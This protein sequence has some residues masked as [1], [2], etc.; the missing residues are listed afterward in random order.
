MKKYWFRGNLLVL[1]VLAVACGGQTGSKYP[2]PVSATVNGVTS[3]DATK[4][5]AQLSVSA[6][7]AEG[8]LLEGG[9]ISNVQVTTVNSS[10][11]AGT[12][13]GDVCGNIEYSG[14]SINAILMLDGSGSMSLTDPNELR[15]DAAKQFVDRMSATDKAAIGSFSDGV[16]IPK[17]EDLTS[18]KIAL[19]Q[20]IDLNTYVSGGTNLWG[21]TYQSTD[22]ISTSTESN[23]IAVV[24]TDGEDNY[25]TYSIQ[26]I[27]DNATSKSVK[28]FMV[29]LG[30]GI[31][32]AQMTQVAQG[33][34]G[35]YSA[36]DN[37]T[38]LNNLFNGAFNAATSAGCIELTFN[39]VPPTGTKLEG[40]INFEVEDT[41]LQAPFTISF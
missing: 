11:W 41:P 26:Q 2:K 30:S 12:G 40:E 34:T 33:T 21:A 8:K 35:L 17:L 9:S 1:L 7:D 13:S 20:A 38:D 19:K 24:F 4:G 15:R 36:V 16:S 39:P 23:K 14:G 28:I 6:L 31:N 27:I 29:G 3:I 32:S 22:Y 37:A 18:D 5:S 25:G 10:V